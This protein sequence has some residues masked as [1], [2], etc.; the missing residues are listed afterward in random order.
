MQFVLTGFTNSA[1]LRVFKFEGVAADRTRTD[2]SVSADMALSRVHGIRIQELPLLC[3]RFL[4][5]RDASETKHD[6]AFGE[7]DMRRYRDNCIAEKDASQRKKA[8]RRPAPVTT[9][10][11]QSGWSAFRQPQQPQ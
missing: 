2:F 7:A 9:T 5:E 1:G 11:V 8:P 3:L 4:E 10:P 6:L